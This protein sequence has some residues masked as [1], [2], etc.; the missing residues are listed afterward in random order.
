MRPSRPIPRS[1]IVGVWLNDE[2]V[3]PRHALRIARKS[4]GY[5]CVSLSIDCERAQDAVRKWEAGV[6]C[7]NTENWIDAMQA[8]GYRIVVERDE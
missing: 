3:A 1:R 6:S 5:S 8:C 4:V 7:P 2:L